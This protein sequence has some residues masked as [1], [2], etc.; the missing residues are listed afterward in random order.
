MQAKEGLNNLIFSIGFQMLKIWFIQMPLKTC[1]MRSNSVKIPFFVQ[2]ITKNR[3]E[4]RGLCLQTPAVSGGLEI[5]PQTP[6]KDIFELQNTSLLNTY[7]NLDI[8][9]FQLLV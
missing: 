3:P 8:S 4:G 6:V 9:T 7:P 2:K 1:E 5:R